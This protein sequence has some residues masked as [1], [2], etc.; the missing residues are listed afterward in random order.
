[1]SAP[2]KH[3]PVTLQFVSDWHVGTGEGRVGVVDAVV[4]RDGDELP[5][6]PAKTLLGVWRDACETVARSLDSPDGRAWQRWVGWLFGSPP[7]EHDD[8]TAARQGAP[9]SAALSL[10][11]ARLAPGLREAMAGKTALRDALVV[12]RPGVALDEESGTARDDMLRLEERALRGMVLHAAVTVPHV[13]GGLPPA[14]ELLLRAG[15]RLV[16]AVGGKRNRGSGRLVLHVGATP[17]GNWADDPREDPPLDPRLTELLA[18]EELVRAPGE[19]PSAARRHA[20]IL[21]DGRQGGPR[22]RWRLELEVLSPVVIVDRV[23]GNDITTRDEIPGTALLPALLS[24]LPAGTD[25][26]LDDVRVGDAVPAAVDAD[27]TARPSRHEP[28]VWQRDD[29]GRGDVVANTLQVETDPARRFKASRGRV[30]RTDDDGS[31]SA[32]VRFDPATTVSTHVVV[33]GPTAGAGGLFSYHGIAPG[34]VLVSDLVL[35]DGIE[36]ALAPGNV[37]RLGR[38]RKDD[39]GEVR[40]RHLAPRDDPPSRTVGR[41]G[42]LRVWLVSDLLLRDERLAFDPTPDRLAHALGGPDALNVPLTVV[43]HDAVLRPTQS[44][45]ARREGFA[46]RWGRPRASLVGLRAGSVVTFRLPDGVVVDPDRVE[47][48]ERDGVG[49]RTVEGYGR[50]LLDP[51][52]LLV[53]LPSVSRPAPAQRRRA[54]ASGGTPPDVDPAAP[55]PVELSAWRREI[56]RRVAAVVTAGRRPLVEGLAR[57]TPSQRGVLR[58]HVSRLGYPGGR[59]VVAGWFA[60]LGSSVTRQGAWDAATLAGVR[61]LLLE[62]TVWHELGLDGD[63]SGLLLIEGREGL[64]RDALEHEAVTALVQELARH[65]QTGDDDAPEEERS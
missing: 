31:A 59:E 30:A 20:P 19:P 58:A 38:S 45:P 39:Y 63:Q 8:E 14:A 23:I 62:G 9:A 64:L 55:H 41:D 56:R 10:T 32:W 37:L 49:D 60:T 25:I 17:M 44:R 53:D 6:V 48:V 36:L 4:R 42:L 33:N 3:L 61:G 26:G 21:A 1:M 16:D 28:A 24:R 15:A 46:P 65:A 34:T 22:R 47:R 2:V 13:D 27:G 43:P 51:P 50:L 52:E 7:S 12:L 29:K 5:F 18:D 57:A 54:Q 11:S 40:V 35:P